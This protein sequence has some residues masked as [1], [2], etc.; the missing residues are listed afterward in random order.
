MKLLKRNSTQFEVWPYQGKQEIL[1][2]GRHT[3][4]YEVQYGTPLEMVGHI[5]IPSGFVQNKWFGIET[6]YT[7][8][9]IMDNPNA[10]IHE[11]DRIH[12][13]GEEYDVQ[14]VKPSINVLNVALRRIKTAR[15][16]G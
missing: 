8:L 11:A 2:E 15:S 3:G 5:S 9:L 7:H 10:E 12:W 6:D 16:G 13:K 14:A 4:R 1:D